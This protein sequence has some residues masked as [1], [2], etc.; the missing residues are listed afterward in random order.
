[1]NSI[2]S[3]KVFTEYF[4][5]LTKQK[6]NNQTCVLQILFSFLAVIISQQLCA[7]QILHHPQDVVGMIEKCGCTE[8]GFIV[9][10][11]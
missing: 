11:S 2:W 1:V 6:K 4:K 10:V 8:A 5:V 7:V 9:D 3:N